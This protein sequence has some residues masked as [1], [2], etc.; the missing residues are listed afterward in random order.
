MLKQF[1]KAKKKIDY[2][3]HPRSLLATTITAPVF[4]QTLVYKL[5]LR[6]HVTAEECKLLRV[7]FIPT[8]VV[9]FYKTV[10]ERF[11]NCIDQAKKYIF[12]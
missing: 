5:N 11:D 10:C 12:E 8:S 4:V 1:C 3:K 2:L 6:W 7:A 9:L